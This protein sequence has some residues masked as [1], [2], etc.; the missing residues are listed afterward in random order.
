METF[1]GPLLRYVSRLLSQRSGAEDV[2][3]NTFVKCAAR[4]KGAMVPGDDLAAWL[5]R[6][7]FNE[8]LDHNRRDQRRWRLHRRQAEA[9]GPESGDSGPDAMGISEQAVAAASALALLSERERQ[10]V[11][12]KVYE[13]KSY[14]QM[15]E[16]TGLSTGNVGYILHGAMKKLAGHLRGPEGGLHD[17]P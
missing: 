14:K 3:Q 10:L 13:E 1:Q 12:L 2:V 15:A 7:A 9:P 5:Y 17:E 16:I 8:A 4:W 6:V 11:T